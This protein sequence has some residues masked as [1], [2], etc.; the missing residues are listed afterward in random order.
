MRERQRLARR[1]SKSPGIGTPKLT[2]G[3]I[4]GG[5]NTNVVP[6]RIVMRL[7]RRLIPEENGTQGRARA[8]RADQAR[9]AKGKGIS[10][11][12]R[13]IILAEPL[14]PRAGRRAAGRAAP[15]PRQARAQ[16]RDRGQGRAA[17]HR[18]AALQRARHPD[19]ALRRRARA[20][21]SRRTRTGA[22][23]HI[24]LSDLKAATR[25]IA[26]TLREMLASK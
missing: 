23:E 19:R 14:K 15:A 4:S 5:I 8:D 18:R 2:V 9:G 20:R 10:V 1:K 26:A 22:D 6:D 3:L 12:C 13:R 11:E 7:D 24:K 16:G 21:S 25:V 17:L